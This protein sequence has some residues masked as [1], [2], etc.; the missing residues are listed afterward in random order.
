M[1]RRWSGEEK[2]KKINGCAG[3]MAETE[4]RPTKEGNGER[5]KDTR[6]ERRGGRMHRQPRSDARARWSE[7]TEET[8]HDSRAIQKRLACLARTLLFSCVRTSARDLFRSKSQTDHELGSL[9]GETLLRAASKLQRASCSNLWQTLT[10][11]K[12]CSGSG[13]P[14]DPFAN[15]EHVSRHY[16]CKTLL[17]SKQLCNSFGSAKLFPI[18]SFQNDRST[19]PV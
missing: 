8:S 12:H 13:A 11:S 19:F 5:K 15:S 10:N 18:Y 3:S 4:E 17:L 2:I 9:A 16:N 7:D 14:K 1:Q 6:N